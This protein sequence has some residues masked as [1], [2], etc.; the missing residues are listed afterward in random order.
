MERTS[1][2]EAPLLTSYD[3]IEFDSH[4]RPSKVLHGRA[5]FKLKISQVL[6][7]F[8]KKKKKTAFNLFLHACLLPFVSIFCLNLSTILS[9]SSFALSAFIQV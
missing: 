9:M 8:K 5:S 1:D 3:G 6:S 7:S 4:D 2:G